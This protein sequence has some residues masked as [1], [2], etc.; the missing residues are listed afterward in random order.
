MLIDNLASTFAIVTLVPAIPAIA[1]P[2]RCEK[3][4][5]RWMLAKIR[6]W[7]LCSISEHNVARGKV[8]LSFNV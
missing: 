8:H 4:G 3:S 6:T 2:S 1:V 7:Q 5:W